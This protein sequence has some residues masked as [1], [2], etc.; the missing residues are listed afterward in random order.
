MTTTRDLAIAYGRFQKRRREGIPL[1]I[2]KKTLEKLKKEQ[3]AHLGSR[4]IKRDPERI[5]KLA[6][7]PNKLTEAIIKALS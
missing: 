2:P 5:R 7:K 4:S 6:G 3:Q 1:L